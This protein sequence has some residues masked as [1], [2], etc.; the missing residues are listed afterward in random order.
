M[1]PS[2]ATRCQVITKTEEDSEDRW[3][4]RLLRVQKQFTRR[5]ANVKEHNSQF[6]T[7][8]HPKALF[9]TVLRQFLSIFGIA[10]A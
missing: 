6:T 3:R 2:D 7:L 1:L 9:S 10:V 4:E 8:P 5:S